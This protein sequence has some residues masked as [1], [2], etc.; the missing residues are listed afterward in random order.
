[1]GPSGTRRR[2]PRGEC[3]VTLDDPAL[4]LMSVFSNR[5]GYL[6]SHPRNSDRNSATFASGDDD[7]LMRPVISSTVRLQ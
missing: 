4:T 7:S 5:R 6:S 2:A 3:A 1:M